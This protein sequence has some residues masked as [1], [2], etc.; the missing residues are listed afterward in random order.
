MRQF[1]FETF[2]IATISV[3]L[4][5]VILQLA[6]PPFSVWMGQ[7]YRFPA[8]FENV[9]ILAGFTLGVTLLSGFY[10]S[11]ILSS[12]QPV[13][14]L[15][16]KFSRSH[17]GQTARKTLVILQFTVSTVLLMSIL[18]VHQQ[19]EF[20]RQTPLGYKSDAVVTVNF[21]GDVEVQKHYESI[22]NQLL[23]MSYILGV[24]RHNSN[25]VGGLGNGWI[26]TENSDGKEVTTSIY[27]MNVDAD[28]FETYRMELVAGR[29]FSK[30]TSDSSKS[31]LVNEATM[32]MLGWPTPE[33]AIGKPFGKGEQERQVIGVV[34]DFHFESLH[35]RVEPLLIG[36]VQ[37]GS[38]ISLR[39]ERARLQDGVSHLKTV[40]EEIVPN[41]PLQY[42]FIDDSLEQQYNSEQK[43]QSVFYIFAGLSFL[44]ACMGLFGLSIFMMQQRVREIGIRKVLGAQVT[45]ILLLLTKD[46]S[47]LVLISAFI[48]I[49]LGWFSMQQWL[50]SFAYHTGIGWWTYALAVLI[51][52]AIALLTVSVQSIKAALIN[53]AKILRTE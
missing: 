43:M 23:S 24:T 41:V 51:P 22:R 9:S 26:T 38:S 20:L 15:K 48:A 49:P 42:N 27:R 31:V 21:N 11:V 39:F 29:T 50:E 6:L 10:P 33:H 32:K 13:A 53:P 12:F 5:L 52:V 4:S 17:S 3:G 1:F 14:A 30:G 46:F 36:H 7:P 18:T 34:K 35:K 47:K 2:V 16:G 37:G 8:T 19:M 28:Y 45:G 44:I 25:V 40:W